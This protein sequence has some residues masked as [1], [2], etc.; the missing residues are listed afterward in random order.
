MK[1]SNLTI[2]KVLSP[3]LLAAGLIIGLLPTTASATAVTGTASIGGTV[4]VTLGGIFFFNT[5]DTTAN[6]F[7]AG[8]GSGS[9]LGF[10]GGTI[11]NLVGPPTTG[12]VSIVDFATFTGGAVTPIFFNLTNIFPGGGTAANCSSNAVG[13]PASVCTPTGSPFTLTQTPTGVTIT[14]ALSGI[15]YSGTSATSSPTG[16]LFTAQVTVPGT[17]T[18]VLAQVAAPGGLQDQT[19]SATFTSVAIPEPATFGLIGLSLVG[20]GMLA[21][22]RRVRS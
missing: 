9:Y 3:G 1:L 2:G 14:L 21:R 10:T 16:G 5:P 19:Y 18:S 6:I 20:L 17:I 4:D 11:Q 7:D 15:A 22:K 13:P 12:P 8:V